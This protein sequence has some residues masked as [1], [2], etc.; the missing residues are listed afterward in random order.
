MTS[1]D[2]NESA[3]VL[4]WWQRSRSSAATVLWAVLAIGLLVLFFLAMRPS[5]PALNTLPTP[6]P[7]ATPTP[8]TPTVNPSHTLILSI[9]NSNATTMMTY[10]FSDDLI[11]QALTARVDGPFTS[12]DDLRLRAPDVADYLIRV[13]EGQP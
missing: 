10:A 11:Q 7:A 9:A 8:A 13:T 5:V 3:T 1:S 6:T 4:S 12:L 2:R